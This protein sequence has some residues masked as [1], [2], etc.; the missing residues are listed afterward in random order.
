MEYVIVRNAI[1]FNRKSVGKEK[2]T[3]LQW[4]MKK[5]VMKLVSS[6]VIKFEI[7]DTAMTQYREFLSNEMV[8]HREKILLFERKKQTWWFVFSWYKS[9]GNASR[10]SHDNEN[11]IHIESWRSQ[12]WTRLQWQ[13][14]CF[15]AEPEA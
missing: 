14:C 13:Q 4:R 11:H 2:S 1:C 7:G 9:G 6:K 15:K 5:H 10:V 8:Q 12:C 3:V